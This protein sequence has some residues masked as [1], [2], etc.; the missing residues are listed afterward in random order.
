[1]QIKSLK[2]ILLTLDPPPGEFWHGDCIGADVQF[3]DSVLQCFGGRAEFQLWPSTLKSRAHV[4][5]LYRFPGNKYTIHEPADA[6]Q[7]TIYIAKSS[8]LL[9]VTPFEADI[10][11]KGG[12]W[13]AYHTGRAARK[14]VVII[15]PSGRTEEK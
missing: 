6:R 4:E 5:I 15:W 3:H 12:T 2:Q 11:D 8:K 7:R 10:Q 9:I 14:Q 13:L 1:M